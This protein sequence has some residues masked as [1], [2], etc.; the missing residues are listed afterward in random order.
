MPCLLTPRATQPESK[1]E[2]HFNPIY[3]AGFAI[4]GAIALG[5]IIWLSLRLSR[6]RA[7]A[8]RES[9]LGPAFLSVR[10][11]VKD[12][13]RSG[14]YGIP[15]TTFSRGQI[16]STIVMPEKVLAK[17]KDES[18][19]ETV[20]RQSQAAASL[21][22]H[23]SGPSLGAIRGSTRF[24]LV[25][26]HLQQNIMSQLRTT[27]LIP[28]NPRDRLSTASSAASSTTEDAPTSTGK[29]RKVRQLFTPVLPDELLLTAFGEQL[30]VIQS[31]DDGWCLVG[32][33]NSVFANTAKSLFKRAS[34]N[35]NVEVGVVPAWCF[36]KSVK[37]LRAERP[38]R[39]SSLGITAPLQESEA[40]S[41]DEVLSWSNF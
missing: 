6:K 14:L 32:R 4:V 1:P 25:D 21:Y 10:G 28:P 27:I 39:N 33:E 12:G 26:A 8:K 19:N 2:S 17:D 15:N 29:K 9:K 40:T 24:S 11:V 23:H 37:G 36:I 22:S 34:V 18:A 3:A 35:G 41:R 13:E 20:Q 31:F 16:D 7:K 30:T 5:L 38:L